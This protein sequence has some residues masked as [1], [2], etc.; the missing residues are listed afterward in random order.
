V[1]QA[2]SYAIDRK[3]MVDNLVRG[4]SRVM[5]SMCFIEQVGCTEEGV[6]RYEYDPAKAKKLLAE[7][8]YPDGFDTT[9][10]AYREREYAEAM[11]GYLR[12][13]GI[14][15]KLNYMKYAAL[16]EESRAGK[17]PLNFTTWGSFSVN[18]ASAFTSVYFKFGDDDV[19]RD[20]QVRDW[21]ATADAATDPAAR[22]ENYAKALQRIADQAYALPLFS[23]SSNYAFTSDLDFSAQADEL[24]RFYDAHW[25]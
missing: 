16:R 25:K 12:A 3:A 18:D 5:N 17:V 19:N 2:I 13:V 20:P 9:I 23:Y 4:G 7:A 14:R 15:A 22:K 11:I 21:L 6:K 10:Y 24:P 1:R 8:G